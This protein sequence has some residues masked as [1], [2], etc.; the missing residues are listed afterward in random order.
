MAQNRLK[1]FLLIDDDKIYIFLVKGVLKSIS[2]ES[3]VTSFTDPSIALQHLL[4]MKTEHFNNLIIFLDLNMPVLNGWD[5]LDKLREQFGNK[6]PANAVIHILSSSDISADI[7]RSKSFSM[8]KGFLT[9]P[10]KLDAV[11]EILAD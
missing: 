5:V 4:E 11:R 10:L 1:K 3:E 2:P 8:V 6:L 9:K 7:M